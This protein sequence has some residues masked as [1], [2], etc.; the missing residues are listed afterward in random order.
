MA[1]PWEPSL[2]RVRM[3]MRFDLCSTMLMALAVLLFA[4]AISLPAI[5]HASEPIPPE[6]MDKSGFL[7]HGGRWYAT[8]EAHAKQ[9]ASGSAIVVLRS[10]EHAGI[11]GVGSRLACKIGREAMSRSRPAVRP[12]VREYA[13]ASARFTGLRGLQERCDEK[14]RCL[15][16]VAVPA[17]GIEAGDSCSEPDMERVFAW[18]LAKER[19]GSSILEI[20]LRH[21]PPGSTSFALAWERF[22]KGWTRARPKLKAAL[23][24]SRKIESY[25]YQKHR[26]QRAIAMLEKAPSDPETVLK[27]LDLA[28]FEALPYLKMAEISAR[29]Q[30]TLAGLMWSEKGLMLGNAPRESLRLYAKLR[31]EAGLGDWEVY[32]YGANH[33]DRYEEFITMLEDSGFLAAAHT[34]ASFGH[35]PHSRIQ[36]P[37]PLYNRAWQSFSEK[38][39]QRAEEI[40][41]D[42]IQKRPSSPELHNLIGAVY[43]N[44]DRCD[45]ALPFLIQATLLKPGFDFPLANLYLCA[46]RLRL[47]S[48]STFYRNHPVLLKSRSPWVK[49]VLG[50]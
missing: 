44:Q 28:L 26:A 12:R 1:A 41:L 49:Q 16:T 11:K 3:K 43:R 33:Q 18:F 32:Q 5:S 25:R 9:F 23:S 36:G 46:K 24:N 13:S 50:Q 42:A 8:G 29:N 27:A 22:Q 2:A 30:G 7:I 10:K 4:G 20:I 17:Q 47:S 45:L 6:I 40:L 14:G 21:S 39:L 38:K 19:V 48:A 37:G 35:A 34:V 15:V 31:Q